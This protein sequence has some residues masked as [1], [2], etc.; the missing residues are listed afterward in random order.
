MK[1][2]LSVSAIAVLLMI[3]LMR[4]QGSSLK[5]TG[6]PRAII[7]LEFADTSQ[8]LQEL[9]LHWDITVVKMNIWLDFLFIVTYVLFLSIAAEFSAIK[10]GEGLMQKIGFWLARIAYVAG[11]L[12]IAE[13][14]LMLQSVTGNFTPG[15]LQLTYYCA[16]V[17]FILAA[18]VIL[19][20][21]ISLP[22]SLRKNKD[23]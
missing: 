6:S 13:N 1:K 4:V 18:C 10:W 15:S 14:L 8:R 21:L 3:I 16:A 22:V 2:K 17:K 7:D 12:D 5:T 23:R 9:I 20:L 11:M 19:Y